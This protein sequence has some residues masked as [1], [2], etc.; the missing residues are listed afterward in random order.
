MALTRGIVGRGTLE[1]ATEELAYDS[2]SEAT[3]QPPDRGCTGMRVRC[4]HATVGCFV[5]IPGIHTG[6]A[7]G[8]GHYLPPVDEQNSGTESVAIFRSPGITQMFISGDAAAS[9]VEWG[10]VENI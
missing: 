6:V 8:S 1:N 4:T 2:R 10:A 7:V 9:T 3:A 5:R